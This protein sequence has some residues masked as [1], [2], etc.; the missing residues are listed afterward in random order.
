MRF[1]VL[2]DNNK[3]GICGIEEGL[4]VYFDVNGKK[5][6]LDTGSSDLFIKNAELLNINLNEVDTVVLSHGHWDHGNGLKQIQGRKVIL[7]PDSFTDRYSVS[8]NMQYAGLN[9]ELDEMSE[10]F[11][12]IQSREPYV[13]CDS[14]YFLGQIPRIV[15]FEGEGNLST[16]LDPQTEEKDLTL[17]DSGIVIR[18]EGGS[19]V[20]S[21]CAHAGICN[22]IEHAKQVA[23]DDRVL[24]VI[25]GF[26][27]RKPDDKVMKTMQYFVDNKIQTLYMGHCNSDEVIQEFERQL[28]G[29]CR[30]VRL[31]S[32][33]E[34]EIK[35]ESL[36]Q[37][38]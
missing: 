37:K 7:H 9:Q 35:E 22:T 4:S 19:I 2:V 23:K 8:R 11:D 33:A 6:L 38:H 14:V 25:G 34:F 36:C 24:A 18:T 13:I 5:I 26:H 28:A 27:L 12:V 15:D 10:K 20:V 31:Y 30:I 21:G 17:D 1:V 16:V 3:N 32:G 29:K